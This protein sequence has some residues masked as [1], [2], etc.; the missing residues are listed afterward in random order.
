MVGII[1]RP[2]FVL[3]LV[4]NMLVC[5]TVFAGF[6]LPRETVSGLTGRWATCG[7]TWQMWLARRAL[8]PFINLLY[9]WEV[10]HCRVTYHMEYNVRQILYPELKQ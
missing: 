8:E 6:A 10:D 1:L 4:L 5:A 7:N 3:Y 2:V 9:F